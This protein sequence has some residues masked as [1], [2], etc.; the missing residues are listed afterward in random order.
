MAMASLVVA[1]VLLDLML[2]AVMIPASSYWGPDVATIVSLL[3]ASLIV[4]YVF[5]AKIHEG[6]RIRAIGKTVVLSA[7]VLMFYTLGLSAN[8]YAGAALQ[9]SLESMYA[10]SAWTTWD[11]VAY[12]SL[13]MVMLVGLNVVF[14]LAFGFIGLYA[15]SMLRKPKKSQT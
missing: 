4:G 9:E 2:S 13:L 15:G 14:A 3:A 6:S 10:T 1:Y 5:A 7:V 12:S 11:W 8:P